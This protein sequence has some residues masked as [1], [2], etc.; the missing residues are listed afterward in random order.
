[1]A[2]RPPKSNPFASDYSYKRASADDTLKS[3]LE[4]D[5]KN[6]EDI[7]AGNVS[8]LKDIALQMNGH[9]KGEADLHKD[10][11]GQFFKVSNLMDATTKRIDQILKSGGGRFNCY[12]ILV[13]VFFLVILWLFG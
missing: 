13:V 5:Y 7:L 4:E 6:H 1:M 10:M 8:Q 12:L 3:S 2:K 9:L 11:D